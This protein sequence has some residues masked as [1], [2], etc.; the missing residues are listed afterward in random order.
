MKQDDLTEKKIQLLNSYQETL[1]CKIYPAKTLEDEIADLEDSP[2][3]VLI[4]VLVL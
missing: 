4:E 3:H 2:D 1:K